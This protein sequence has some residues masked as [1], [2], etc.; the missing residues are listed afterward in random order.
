[1][2]RKVK[3]TQ[4]KHCALEGLKSLT[5][6]RSIRGCRGRGNERLNSLTSHQGLFSYFVR[7][8]EPPT[9]TRGK[10]REEREN[11]EISE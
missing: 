2:E 11:R 6:Q 10:T 3:E 9:G 4:E 5:S 8:Q 1:M 7:S